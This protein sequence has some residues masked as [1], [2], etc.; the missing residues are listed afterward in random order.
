VTESTDV[1]IRSGSRCGLRF[2]SNSS[3]LTVFYA[4]TMRPYETVESCGECEEVAHLQLKG[5]T[6]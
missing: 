2:G 1:L 6:R 5:K 4:S 3:A